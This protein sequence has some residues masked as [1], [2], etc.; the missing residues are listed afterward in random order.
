[1]VDTTVE[2]T[3]WAQRLDGLREEKL[4]QTAEKQEVLGA[5]D[6]DDWAMILPPPELR[7][8]VDAMSSSG[9]PIKDCLLSNY[10]PKSNHPSGGFFGARAV[11]ENY[12]DLLKVHPVYV[13][14]RSTLAGGYMVNFGSYREVGWNPDF[15]YSHL[16]PYHERY[17]LVP[18]IGGGQHFCQ[19]MDIG[20]SLGWSGLLDKIAYYRMENSADSAEFYDGLVAFIEGMQDWIGRHVDAAR[21]MA[22]IG[23]RSRTPRQPA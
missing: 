2:R 19:E 1:M 9:M 16:K 12:R 11:G 14:P 6:H 7:K 23:E 5:Q 15:D 3:S 21:E 22:G 4:A 17:G 20:L 13:D 18:G 10:T 8:L